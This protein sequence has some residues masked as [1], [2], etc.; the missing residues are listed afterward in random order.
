M[1]CQGAGLKKTLALGFGEGLLGSAA[2]Q[3][4]LNENG[5]INW[6]VAISEGVFSVVMAGVVWRSG[7]AEINIDKKNDKPVGF[8][9]E[10]NPSDNPKVL[11]DA[12]E[13]S[14]AVYGYSPR[15]DSIRIGDFAEYDWT[16]TNVVLKAKE[17]RLQYHRDNDDIYNIINDMNAKGY[18]IEEIAREANKKRD[19][20]RLQSYIDNG[21]VNGYERAVN[22]NLKNF[23][24]K[25][26]MIPEQAFEK[27]GS[28]DVV[29]EK[30]TGANAG[31][32]ACCGLYDEFYYL[33]PMTGRKE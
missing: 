15:P 29:L 18:S 28:W 3:G 8:Q 30:A 14:N 10:H 26:G 31:M 5:K 33:Y 19:A 22:S 20:N 23:G 12:I 24:N 32:D 27:Y 4:I 6:V 1:R 7:N 25:L 17:A 2:T 21:N 9:Y 11:R 13:D 16:D